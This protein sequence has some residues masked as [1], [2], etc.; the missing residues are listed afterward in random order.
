MSS[1]ITF[2]L[3]TAFSLL[4]SAQGQGQPGAPCNQS[5]GT[6]SC[7]T[8]AGQ[9]AVLQCV[10]GQYVLVQ[11][12][13]IGANTACGLMNG[14]PFCLTP[15]EATAQTAPATIATTKPPVQTF[16][17][18]QACN[19][20]VGTFG[21]GPANA[22]GQDGILV[23]IQGAWVLADHC[24]DE[25]NVRCTIGNAGNVNFPICLPRTPPAQAAVSVPA[26]QAPPVTGQVFQAGQGCNLPIG[27]FGCGQTTAQGQDEILVCIQ[28]AWVVA[29]HC[30]DE[31]NV[32]C[33][34]G[35]AGNVN[36][37]V[38]LPRATAAQPAAATVSTNVA[39]SQ[40]PPVTGQVFQVGQACNL[41]IG[42]FGCGQTTAQ[43]QD[44]ILV[45]IQG[46]WVLA[47]HCDDEENV[48]CTIGNAG[49]V[50]FPVCLP[51]ATAA[52]PGATGSTNVTA[53]QAPPVTGQVFQVGQACNLPIGTFGCGQ[54]TA[55]GQDEILVCIQGAWVLADHCDDE[56]NVRCTIGNAGN[57]NFPVCKPRQ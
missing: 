34:I 44:E 31:E 25:E 32:R 40:A 51:R 35:N 52:Q 20:P 21:C 9:G 39:A 23:C 14:I 46:A 47:D 12:C 1:I 28:N 19:F 29:D 26:S 48:R 27:T 16:Q 43:G 4:V 33:T 17:V 8:N 54:T 3:I 15:A 22:Q 42:T 50:N 56:E 2:A 55:Q 41:P 24:D 45:C 38:C 37:P 10:N 13:N 30:D 7:G 11:T 6:L 57:V 53:S 5:P 18:G 49:N 36:F